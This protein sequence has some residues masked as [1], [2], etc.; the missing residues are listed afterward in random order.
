M[1]GL[2]SIGDGYGYEITGAD[3]LDAYAAVVQAAGAAGVDE[4][5]V[6]ADL[7]ALIAA[8]RVNGEFL[9]RV[10]VWQLAK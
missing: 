9:G 1:T 3:V 7:R 8:S 4:D 2:R 5:A 6:K 10:L